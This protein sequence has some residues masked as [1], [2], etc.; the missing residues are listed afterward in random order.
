MVAPLD[1]LEEE[2]GPVHLRLR[3]DLQ[4]VAFV[5]V[6]DEDLLLLQHVEVRYAGDTNGDGLAGGGVGSIE[7][8]H[9]G[10]EPDTQ[11]RLSNVRIRS[12]FQNAINLR[13][14]NPTLEN[15]HA[16]E[17]VGAPY[18]FELNTDPVASGLTAR[19]NGLNAFLIQKGLKVVDIIDQIK[20]QGNA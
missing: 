12:G 20:D 3:E 13:G 19:D 8:R 11:T 7:L 5:V 16:Q 10:T 18:Y 14:G 9:S 2:R 6:V 1:D 4:Q 17:N 15:V